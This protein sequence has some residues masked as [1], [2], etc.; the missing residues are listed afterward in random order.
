[1]GDLPIL[2]H[3]HAHKRGPACIGAE[4]HTP[5]LV[6]FGRL[7]TRRV[8][9]VFPTTATGTEVIIATLKT[10]RDTRVFRSRDNNNINNRTREKLLNPVRTIFFKIGSISRR[11]QFLVGSN[12]RYAADSLYPRNSYL[13][14]RFP[15]NYRRKSIT[16]S[17]TRYCV[18]QRVVR[19]L[20]SLHSKRTYYLLLRVSTAL[21]LSVH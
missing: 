16:P 19:I 15:N 5:A 6:S 14:R 17:T 4:Q 7:S 20:Y 10:V 18:V 2:F 13:L 1:V 9:D 8:N 11:R 21:F 3:R 12:H